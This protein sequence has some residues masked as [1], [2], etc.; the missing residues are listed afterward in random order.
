MASGYVRCGRARS[1]VLLLALLSAGCGDA[2]PTAPNGSL[3]Q[4]RSAL[5]PEA[6]AALGS[7]GRFVFPAAVAPGEPMISEARARDL[8]VAFTKTWNLSRGAFLE[9]SRPQGIDRDLQPCDRAYFMESAYEQPLDPILPEH[10]HRVLGAKWIVP[11]CHRGVQQIAIAVP[12]RDTGAA[13]SSDGEIAFPAGDYFFCYQGVADG[14][15]IPPSPETGAV[16][17]SR[18]LRARIT[19][20]PVLRRLRGEGCQADFGA[21]WHYELAGPVEVVGRESGNPRLVTAAGYAFPTVLVH[22]YEIPRWWN[23]NVVVAQNPWYANEVRQEVVSFYDFSIET[24]RPA[25]IVR[26]PDVAFHSEEIAA[27]RR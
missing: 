15:R 17:V 19:G 8:A 23:Y 27:T 10:Y 1:A 20:P 22:Y 12:V 16:A 9:S 5:T 26:R 11:L 25:T 18:A 7:D 14:Y 6:F 21:T 2:V 13:I 24:G 4:L 3:E